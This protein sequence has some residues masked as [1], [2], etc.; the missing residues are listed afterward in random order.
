MEN[1][2]LADALDR[3]RRLA[4]AHH[5]ADLSDAALLD[6]FVSD[7]DGS[8]FTALVERHGALVYGV[9]ARVLRV[10]HDSE[11]ACQ[12]TFLVLAR[13]ASSIRKQSSLPSWLYGVARRVSLALRRERHQR[14]LREQ[15]RSVPEP[16]ST[17]NGPSWSEVQVVLDEE[18]EHLSERFRSPLILCYLEGKTRDEAA[19]ALGLTPGRL[20]GL[21][22]R[23]R[24]LLRERLVKRGLGLGAGLLGTGLSGGAC[25]ALSPTLAVRIVNAAIAAIEG[26]S[27]VPHV[28]SS[29]V[30]SLTTEVVRA[31]FYTKLKSVALWAMCLGILCALVG[32][33]VIASGLASSDDRPLPNAVEFVRASAPVPKGAPAEVRV[34]LRQSSLSVAGGVWSIAFSRDGKTIA[35]G[36]RESGTVTLWDAVSGKQRTAFKCDMGCI[37]IISL[38]PEGKTVATSCMGGPGIHKDVGTIKVWDLLKAKE[39]LLLKGHTYFVGAVAYSPDGSVLASA[40]GDKTVRLWDLATGKVLSTLKHPDSVG[41]LAFHPD[42]KLLATTCGDD[43]LSLWDVA[44]GKELATLALGVATERNLAFSPDGKSIAT[45]SRDHTVVLWDVPTGKE[46][47]FRERVRFRGH[48]GR[49]TSFAISPDG[50]LLAT[51]SDDK[52]VRLWDTATGKERVALKR[53][54]FV[55]VAFSPDGKTLASGSSDRTIRLWDVARELNRERAANEPPAPPGA[56]VLDVPMKGHGYKELQSQVI[57]S[58]AEYDAFVE[59]VKKAP[60]REDRASFLKALAAAKIDFERESLVLIRHTEESPAARVAFVPPTME[61]DTLVCVIQRESTKDDD[62]ED[63]KATNEVYCFALA[64]EKGKVKNVDVS[65][66]TRSTKSD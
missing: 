56:R 54:G 51:G 8:A 52:T 13:K 19:A 37:G 10:P 57:A 27:L 64:V 41:A 29:Q 46:A 50:N 22:Q 26:Q 62:D 59:Q 20:H 17:D 31:M 15:Q 45:Q 55:T 32:G 25:Q 66:S 1:K 3:F 23:G 49:I 18:L 63:D 42:G 9:C 7:R 36:G 5:F 12:A 39:P 44:T 30:F 58:Q 43:N 4:A 35:S 40:G 11:D 60:M 33:A 16:A 47:N 21:L 65:V 48:T 61:G 6:R 34:G 28:V 38:H 14:F 24:D 53:G 2:T